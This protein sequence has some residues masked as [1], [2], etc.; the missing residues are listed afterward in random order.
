MSL[1]WSS[2]TTEMTSALSLEVETGLDISI[3]PMDSLSRELRPNSEQEPS[4]S[5]LLTSSHR[6]SRPNMDQDLAPKSNKRPPDL[7]TN[8][9]MDSMMTSRAQPA[10]QAWP[11]KRVKSRIS[12]LPIWILRTKMNRAM[13]F[14]WA[15]A[16]DLKETA[17]TS[18]PRLDR[19]FCGRAHQAE[20][21]I[22][23]TAAHATD[24][25]IALSI[26]LF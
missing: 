6:T 7:T 18:F 2:M 16:P 23:S 4:K 11:E 5:R 12:P 15:R 26:F 8:P 13:N 24:S 19:R 1:T 20:E 25:P 10:T 9:H 21:T 22:I 14:S 3:R 17:V